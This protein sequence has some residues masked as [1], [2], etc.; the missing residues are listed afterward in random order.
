MVSTT[1]SPADSGVQ[2]PIHGVEFAALIT[3]TVI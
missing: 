1:F 3:Y 2:T